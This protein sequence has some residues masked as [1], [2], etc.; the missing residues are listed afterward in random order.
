MSDD[1]ESVAEP[2][3]ADTPDDPTPSAPVEDP[4]IGSLS[5]KLG[6]LFPTLY[7]TPTVVEEVDDGEEEEEEGLEEDEAGP[8]AAAEVLS[9]CVEEEGTSP[10][11]LPYPITKAARLRAEAAQKLDDLTARQAEEEI[12]ALQELLAERMTEQ[13]DADEATGREMKEVHGLDWGRQIPKG[14]ILLNR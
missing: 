3:E 1:E 14:R 7:H 13:K 6:E 11:P 4:K 2:L 5:G 9:E 8:A 10:N 12:A